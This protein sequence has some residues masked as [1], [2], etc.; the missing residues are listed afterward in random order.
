MNIQLS[1]NF[2][3]SKLIKF[4]SPTIFMMIFTSIYGI[5]DG[6]FVSNL[7][8][9][10][11]FAAV[12]L[13]LPIVTIGGVFG[14][15]IGTGGGALVSKII[16][17]G[18]NKKGNEVFS[19]LTYLLIILGL[20]ITVIGFIFIEPISIALGAEGVVLEY[21]ILYGRILFISSVPFLLQNSFQSFLVVA[22]KPNMG[23]VI[24]VISGVINIVVDIVLITVFDM[25]IIGV[26]IGTCIGQVIGGI[27]PLIYFMKKNKSTLRLVKAKW[28]FK[29]IAQ[30]CINGSS[31]MFV[32]LSLSLVNMLYNMQLIKLAGIDGV[33]SYGVIMYITFIFQGIYMGYAI[34]ITPIVGYHYGADNKDELKSLLKK[35]L[36][37][38]LISSLFLTGLGELSAEMLAKI[39]VSYD[40]DL[41]NMTTIAIRIFSLSYIVCGFNIFASA[42]FTGLNNGIVSGV[43]SFL[44]TF[45]FQTVMIF[46]LPLL[47]GVNGIWMA[48][49]FAEILALFISFICFVKNKDKYEYI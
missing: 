32:N 1:D 7:I 37:L 2:T 47:F 11:A 42:F 36:V 22:E 35:S 17:E 5:L 26:A 14:L 20:I 10:D 23:L 38:I 34:G 45:V 30:S 46:V 18:D 19:L 40:K 4:T 12:N 49:I 24:S 29:A 43:I 31:E 48:I 25:G 27:I 28:D 13:I 16:G 15:M 44:R 33:V 8:G 9:S 6:L 3:Y 21:C 41:L 39:F